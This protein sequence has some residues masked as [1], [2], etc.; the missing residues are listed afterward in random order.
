MGAE[1]P[2]A[3][4]GLLRKVLFSKSQNPKQAKEDRERPQKKS[5]LTSTSNNRTC[6]HTG[7][8]LAW[9]RWPDPAE[10]TAAAARGPLSDGGGRRRDA[11]VSARVVSPGSS[12]A[13]CARPGPRRGAGGGSEEIGRAH[14]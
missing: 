6:K 10:L 4:P 13:G 2:S 9:G 7:Q 8:P 5:K 11:E 12:L 3:V 14:V 1:Q